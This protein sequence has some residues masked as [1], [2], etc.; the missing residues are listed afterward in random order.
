MGQLRKRGGVAFEL[1]EDA[2]EL[3]L[4]ATPGMFASTRVVLQNNRPPDIQY[5]RSS[6]FFLNYDVLAQQHA[7]TSVTLDA[8]LSI[9]NALWR[10]TCV[11]MSAI[12]RSG[13]T[14]RA[15]R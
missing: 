3:R 15:E 1:A 7:K 2:L 8:G 14:D 12:R 9:R 4:T 11:S 10:P 6:G 5:G 13:A